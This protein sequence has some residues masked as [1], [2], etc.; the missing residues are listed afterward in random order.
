MP[1][2][3]GGTLPDMIAPITEHQLAGSA[4]GARLEMFFRRVFCDTPGRLVIRLGHRKTAK[5]NL[6]DNIEVQIQTVF[7]ISLRRKYHAQHE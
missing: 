3:S 7:A 1:A 5:T 4:R 2:A 6:E